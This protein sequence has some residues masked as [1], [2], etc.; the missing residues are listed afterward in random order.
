MEWQEKGGKHILGKI[1]EF[2]ENKVINNPNSSDEPETEF[3]AASKRF[4]DAAKLFLESDGND[5]LD[6]FVEEM[7]N[8]ARA[9]FC[10]EGSE[11][12]M[13][14]IEQRRIEFIEN[15]KHLIISEKFAPDVRIK[16]Y[17]NILLGL[18]DEVFNTEDGFHKPF[19]DFS[20]FMDYFDAAFSNY[21]SQNPE[22][23]KPYD[24]SEEMIYGKSLHE[25]IKDCLTDIIQLRPDE[26]DE[27]KA[28]LLHNGYRMFE[29]YRNL[30][31]Y[32]DTILFK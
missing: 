20:Y 28:K 21:G 14:R 11:E 19:D 32:S 12:L 3:E 25:M 9:A 15:N 24:F 5:G 27:D 22:F 26:C 4:N 6:I 23:D 2:N 31:H 13:Q 1:I 7:A 29:L 18:I 10:G 8:L 16:H 30:L 17:A